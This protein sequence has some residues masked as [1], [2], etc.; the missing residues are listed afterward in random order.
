MLDSFSKKDDS[1]VF[2][3]AMTSYDL[4]L[5]LDLLHGNS[6]CGSLVLYMTESYWLPLPTIWFFSKTKLIYWEFIVGEKILQTAA[7]QSLQVYAFFF[8]IALY[9]V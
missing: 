7:A 1:V 5:W 9:E 8:F 2:P 6:S 4:R 3:I